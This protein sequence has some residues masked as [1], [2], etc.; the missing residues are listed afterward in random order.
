MEKLQGART[1]KD[2]T[3]SRSQPPCVMGETVSVGVNEN[4]LQRQRE[5]QRSGAVPALVCTALASAASARAR[6]GVGA[7]MGDDLPHPP[8]SVPRERALGC[9]T[10]N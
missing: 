2:L 1:D 6:I 5:M 10:D 7:K 3:L 4:P 9:G 8:R